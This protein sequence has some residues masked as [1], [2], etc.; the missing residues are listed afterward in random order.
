MHQFFFSTKIFSFQKLEFHRMRHCILKHFQNL[1]NQHSKPVFF[2]DS[3]RHSKFKCLW[4][5]SFLNIL[6]KRVS[7]KRL[8]SQLQKPWWFWYKTATCF[9]KPDHFDWDCR[10]SVYN[11][12]LARCEQKLDDYLIGLYSSQRNQFFCQSA[13][14][15]TKITICKNVNCGKVLN[16]FELWRCQ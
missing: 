11:A 1:L 8:E 16:Q 12:F 3:Q 7:F 14:K 4:V 15:I 6:K 9:L 10:T 2:N 13:S 5:T